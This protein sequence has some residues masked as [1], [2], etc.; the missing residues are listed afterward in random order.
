M[1]AT[2][3]AAAGMLIATA[4]HNPLLALP[5]AV[6]SHFVLDALPHYAR[7]DT[8]GMDRL[9]YFVLAFDMFAVLGL[10]LGLLAAHPVYWV[11][12][13][14][15]GVA[16]VSVDMFWIYR[17]LTIEKFGRVPPPKPHHWFHRMHN[18][19]QKHESTRGVY[20]ELIIGICLLSLCVIQFTRT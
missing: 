9:A 7:D 4:V 14:L 17:F 13:L 11:H 19:V 1:T 10:L 8:K 12:I 20:V 5:L 6:G 16:A 3:H 18:A 2:N 15:G